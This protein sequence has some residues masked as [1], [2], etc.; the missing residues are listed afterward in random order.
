[1]ISLENQEFRW[2]KHEYIPKYM[3]ADELKKGMMK[4]Y[5]R[6]HSRENRKLRLKRIKEILAM[7]N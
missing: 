3:S 4:L 7:N 1:L 6:F 5:A 2:E